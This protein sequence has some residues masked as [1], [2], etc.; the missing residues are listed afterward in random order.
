MKMKPRIKDLLTTLGLATACAASAH[1]APL[2]TAFT[3]QGKLTDGGQPANGTYDFVFVIYSGP[4]NDLPLVSGVAVEDVT[5]TNG[6][7]S[8]QVE[9]VPNPF[10]GEVRWLETSVR[11]GTESGNYTPLLPRQE[12]T[13]MPYALH[14]QFAAVAGSVTNVPWSAVS[15]LPATL[16]DG[17]DNDTKYT[18]GAGL[19]LSP[20]NQFSVTYAGNGSATSAARSDHHHLGQEWIGSTNGAILR[21]QNTSN[22]GIGFWGKNDQYGSGYA[23]L[24]GAGVFGDSSTDPGVAGFSNTGPGVYGW[25][26]ALIGTYDAVKGENPSSSGRAVAGY[27][28][29]T[30]GACF[31]VLGQTASGGGGVGVRGYATP[32]TGSSY[33]GRFSNKSPDGAA[34][35]GFS[36]KSTVALLEITTPNNSSPVVEAASQGTGHA[37]KFTVNNAAS[38]ADALVA[39][40]SGK[41][42]A[43][44]AS[45][46]GAGNAANFQL[47]VNHT[48]NSAVL[49]RGIGAA[50]GVKAT[51][52]TG[53]ALRAESGGVALSASAPGGTALEI[54]GGAMRVKGAGINTSTAAFV[55]RCTAANTPPTGPYGN[56][57]TIIDN[58][59]CNGRSDAILI[60]TPRAVYLDGTPVGFQELSVD[61]DGS[62]WNLVNTSLDEI[63]DFDEGD[64]FNILVILP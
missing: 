43:L 55:H 18:A 10:N 17:V 39:Q 8:A 50:R 61:Y 30:N 16:A 25:I 14:A 34:I 9:F 15:Q 11:L 36:D 60:V 26:S 47:T 31:G 22:S 33:G 53:Q 40:T 63:G 21:I 5:V 48:N 57:Y 38:S 2:G 49:A 13:A 58:A 35:H 52:G 1:A 46:V 19:G 20:Q 28:T 4:T 54:D 24:N 62:R 27:A 12:V 42:D 56:R 6:V 44:F 59:L 41:G 37:G 51:S 64:K 29:A 7:F 45:T 3:Y 23:P 32:T